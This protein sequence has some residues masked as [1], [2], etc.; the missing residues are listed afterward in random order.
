M[1]QENFPTQASPQRYTAYMDSPIGRIRLEA[2]DTAICRTEWVAAAET[3]NQAAP[4]PLLEEAIRQLK[5]YFAG[6]R[7]TF[8]LPLKPEG[9]PFQQ[10][11]WQELLQIPYGRQISYGELARRTGNP[12]ACRAVGSANGKNP[13]FILI[14]CHRV[15]QAGGRIGGYAYGTCM[16]AFL[17]QLEAGA[18]LRLR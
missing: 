13:I 1:K 12:K 11:V 3:G 5:A 14:P 15:V 10:R 17:L 8:E 4:T 18:E 7:T 16:K 6:E 9:T 2:T